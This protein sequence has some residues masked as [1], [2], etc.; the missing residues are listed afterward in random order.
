MQSQ[1]SSIM[2]I[3][4]VL[5]VMN[6]NSFAQVISILGPSER[7]ATHKAKDV[8]LPQLTKIDP[9]EIEGAVQATL[10]EGKSL[11]CFG[12]RV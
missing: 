7:K 10:R 1:L 6:P 11:R 3:K 4:F 2:F 12:L 5:G 9:P 8:T